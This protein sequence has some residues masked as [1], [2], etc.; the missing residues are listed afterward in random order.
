M[1][2]IRESDLPGIGR[3]FQ[4]HAR[5]GDKLVVVVHDDGRRELYHFDPDDPDETVSTVTLDDDEARMMAGIIGGMSYRPKS[6]ETMEVALDALVVEWFKIEAGAGS[7]GHTIGGLNV[8]KQT[9]ATIIAVA[10]K[11]HT[12]CINPGPE[13]VLHAESTLVVAGER[14]QLKALKELLQQGS[15]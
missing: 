2:D 12:H 11:N 1:T 14:K 8:R 3:K 13:Y 10:E 5:G 15:L 7:V 6:L 4:L 9:G